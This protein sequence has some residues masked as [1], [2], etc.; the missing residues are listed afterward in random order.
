MSLW[1]GTAAQ[2]ILPSRESWSLAKRWPVRA[3]IDHHWSRA[4]PLANLSPALLRIRAQWLYIENFI[5]PKRSIIGSVSCPSKDKLVEIPNYVMQDTFNF[6]RFH[7]HGPVLLQMFLSFS[8]AGVCLFAL[9]ATANLTVSSISN[10]RVHN[11][12]LVFLHV[13]VKWIVK[14]FQVPST[15]ALTF[16]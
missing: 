1:D 13:S 4:K 6:G 5:G 8:W 15:L 7:F 11:I 14:G 9:A 2:G 12:A 16:L 3:Q 10:G